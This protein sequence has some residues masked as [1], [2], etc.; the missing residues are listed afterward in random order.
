MTITPIAKG[1]PNWDGPLNAILVQL[2]ANTTAAVATSLQASNNLSDLTNVPVARTN[3]GLSA[4]SVA[5]V[6]NFNVKD[7]GALGNNVADDTTAIQNACNAAA[8]GGTVYFPPGNYLVNS[9]QITVS[10]VG[11]VL[12]GSGAENT[13]INIGSSFTGASVFNLTANTCE[14][15]EMTIQGANSTT[16]SNPV[17]DAIQVNAVRRAK[18]TR[19][20]FWFVNGWCVNIIGGAGTQNNPDG[21]MIRHNIMRSSAGG[22]KFL[23]NTASGFAVNSFIEG[24]E[25]ISGGVTTGASANLDGIHIE[26]SWDI[27]TSNNLVWQTAG[28]GASLHIKG[29]CA[30]HFIKNFDGLGPVTGNCILLEDGPN[31]SPQNVQI[32][33]GVIQQG[34]IGLNI[35]GG[36]TQVRLTSLRFINNQT[37]GAAVAGTG[38]VI[39][40]TDVFFSQSGQGATGSNYD[41]NW[42]GSSNGYIS[43][44][45]FDS[46]IVTIGT[47]GVQQTINFPASAPVRV[48]NCAFGGT[49]ASSA[50]WFTNTPLGVL[51]TTSGQFNFATTTRFTNT[52]TSLT[53]MGNIASQPSAT[54]NTIMS[55]NLNGVAAFDNYRQFGDGSQAWGSGSAARDTFTGRSAAT[56]YYVQPNMIVGSATDLGDN[57]VGEL[58]LANATTVPTTNPTGG[59][60]MYSQGG[61]IKARNPQGLVVSDSGVVSTIQA[62]TT[63]TTTGLQSLN[64][65]T[66]PANDP[67][68]GATYEFVGY[69]VY[70]TNATATTLQLTLYWGTTAGVSLAATPSFTVPASQAGSSFTI[71]AHITFRSTT[72][73][74]GSIDVCMGNGT[75]TAIVEL[76]AS[77][78]PIAV[79]TTS[80]TPITIATNFNNAQ[81]ISITGGDFRR[82]S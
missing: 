43:G 3:L 66:I 49:S 22:I 60:V 2:D 73:A 64:S 9:A 56:V 11:T 42:S 25:I 6:N 54:G 27:L 39:H 69:G 5:G 17:A 26:D 74:V 30:A 40:F 4:G 77:S 47:A 59:A 28:T 51:E 55:S 52:G 12:R 78:A 82:M 63:V 14:V 37:H 44:C 79:V 61:N 76:G 81:S 72:S 46:P 29:S 33:G 23:G 19:C 21:T 24:N 53:S 58:K 18:V 68:A 70:T 75:G 36:A 67:I 50:N 48:F 8:N 34:L 31:G 71:R 10:H 80:A 45:R 13:F 1:T 15:T 16:T 38:A 32:N 41:I 65:F 20:Q 57:G 62:T 7:Y 35:T